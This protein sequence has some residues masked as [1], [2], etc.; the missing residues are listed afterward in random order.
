MIFSLS[1]CGKEKNNENT[2]ASV[3]GTAATPD[4]N[5]PSPGSTA[6]PTLSPTPTSEPTP[7]I[8]GI[9][10]GYS[11]DDVVKMMDDEI[12]SMPAADSRS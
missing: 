8:P 12:D 7:E 1:A 9:P 5:T 11:E 3:T 2:P 4:G 10:D 6:T